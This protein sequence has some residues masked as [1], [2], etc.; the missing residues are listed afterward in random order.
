MFSLLPRW[1]LDSKTGKCSDYKYGQFFSYD[2][3][4]WSLEKWLWE[5]LQ[6]AA[7]LQGQSHRPIKMLAWSQF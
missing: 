1:A 3:E 6:A 4:T 2:N 7:G 5:M